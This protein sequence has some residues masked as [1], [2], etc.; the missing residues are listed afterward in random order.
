MNRRHLLRTSLPLLALVTGLALA[1]CGDDDPTETPAA[2]AGIGTDS[3]IVSDASGGSD[4]S[5][6]TPDGGTDAAATAPVITTATPL[7]PATAGVLYGPLAFMASGTAPITWSVT[8]GTLPPGIALDPATGAYGGT[9]T[10]TGSYAFTVTATNAAGKGSLAVTHVVAEPAADAHVLLTGNRIA[11]VNSSFPSATLTPVALSGITAGETVVG[12][13]RRPQNG[14]LYGLGVDATADTA[15]L[16]AIVPSTGYSQ[17]VGTASQISF[18]D[19]AGTAIDLPASPAASYGVDFN[20]AADRLRIT[21]S[22]GL[23][24]RVNPNSGAAVDGDLG[25]AAGSVAGRNTDGSVN[26]GTSS[27]GE[28]AYTNNA[29]NNGGITTQY[30]LDATSDKLHIQNAPNSGTQTLPLTLSS[31]VDAVLGFDIPSGVNAAASNTA[32]AAGSG[33]AI[34]KLA[35]S[36]TESLVRV[37][38]TNGRL[39]TPQTIGAGGILGLALQKQP[40]LPIVALSDDG[41]SLLRFYKNAPGTVTTVAIAGVGAFETLVG[42]DFRPATGQLFGLGVNATLNT[43]TLYLIDPQT[44]AATV[45]GTQG[46]ISFVDATGLPVDL[47]AASVGY[48]FDFNPTVDRIRVVTGDGKN[49][50]L[51]PITGAAVDGDL[52]GAAGSVN[53]TNTDGNLQGGATKAIGAAYTSSFGGAAV[54]TLY[55]IDADTNSLYIQNPPNAGTLG[56]TLA[57]TVGGSALDFTAVGG[58]D[59]SSDVRAAA[60]NAAATGTAYAALTVAGTTRL[61][62]INLANGQ[63][64]A[65]GAIGAGTTALS[66]LAVGKVD[67]Q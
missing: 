26:G 10:A 11:A 40:E 59:L 35:G 57:I 41:A 37:D 46:G 45:V 6:P 38:L 63:A 48:G 50:R 44:G 64:T 36:T 13:D 16:Y 62:G 47:P 32:V 2:D 20:P 53:G 23:N 25:G 42:V 1:A 66:G 7:A 54:T 30:T 65:I 27:V 18:V 15:T 19:A 12:I 14:V 61:Y 49:F 51:N 67:I 24:F 55:V 17:V 21:T 33:V 60:A 31:A 3:S 22:T 39:S 34:V 58:F 52:G 4:S 5:K 56:G 28:V 8:A 9:P 29:A 43:A